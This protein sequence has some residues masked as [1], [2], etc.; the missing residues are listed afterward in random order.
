MFVTR[1]Q[2]ST[3]RQRV[4]LSRSLHAGAFIHLFVREKYIFHQVACDVLAPVVGQR[5]EELDVS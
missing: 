1:M 4:P 3:L 2:Q 5:V